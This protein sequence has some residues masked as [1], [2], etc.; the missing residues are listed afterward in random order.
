MTTMTRPTAARPASIAAIQAKFA[1]TRKELGEALIERDEEIDLTLTALIAREH[2]LLVGPP[3]CGKSLLLDSL[4]NWTRGSKFSILLTKFTTPEEVVGPISLSALKDDRYRRV[5]T[6]R[7][8]EAELAFIDEIWKASSAILNTLLRM[9]NER[10]F[11]NDGATLPVP[12]RL[13]VAASNEWPSP[14]TGKELTALLD[15]FLFRKSVR[16]IVS[17]SGRRRLLWTRD[18]T[19]KL[20]TTITAADVDAAADAARALP[21]SDTA[22]EAVEAILRELAK[23]GI[24]CGDRRQYK[25]VGAAQAY[26]FLCGADEVRTEHLEVLAHV[27]WDDPVEQPAKCAKVVARIANPVG[28]RVNQY[29]MEAEAVLSATDARNLVQASTATTKLTEILKQLRALPTDP[30]ASKAASYVANEIKRIRL[31]SIDAI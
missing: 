3:G 5:T 27:L 15:R 13:C 25:A 1:A 29:L 6:G 2:V 7:L 30:R 28:M 24:Q 21:W 26:A 4:L 11:E 16:P 22:V 31:A 8:P 23:E 17:S 10:T 18:H 12:L 9:L 19:P 14:D 20:S